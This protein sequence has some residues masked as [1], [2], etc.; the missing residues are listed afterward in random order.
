MQA[1]Q[2]Q[3]SLFK[4]YVRGGSASQCGDA[5][6]VGIDGPTA[7]A[8]LYSGHADFASADFPGIKAVAAAAG[9]AFDPHFRPNVLILWMSRFSVNSGLRLLW[10]SVTLAGS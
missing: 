1:V 2:V 5:F 9:E 6:R 7:P 3:G 10:N 8:F 4:R